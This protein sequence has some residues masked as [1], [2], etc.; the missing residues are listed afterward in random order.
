MMQF[1]AL[2]R[3]FCFLQCTYLDEVWGPTA[4]WI[5]ELKRPGNEVNYSSPIELRF[6]MRGIKPLLPP[7]A[8]M[9]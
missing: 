7:Y 1:L 9:T 2:D 4:Q 5:R 8:F 6:K 3:E